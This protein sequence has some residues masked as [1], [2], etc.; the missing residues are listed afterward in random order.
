MAFQIN[1]PR[2]RLLIEVTGA[3]VG[4]V[5]SC[6]QCA[7]SFTVPSPPPRPKVIAHGSPLPTGAPGRPAAAPKRRRKGPEGWVLGLVLFLVFLAFQ[8]Y[9]EFFDRPAKFP[10]LEPPRLFESLQPSNPIETV[11]KADRDAKGKILFSIVADPEAIHQ[12]IRELSALDVTQ[13]PG[14]IRAA[15]TQIV[16]HF[17]AFAAESKALTKQILDGSDPNIGKSVT[18]TIDRRRALLNAALHE[19]NVLAANYG[20]RVAE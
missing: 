1:C 18:A 12:V 14:D 3:D 6:P 7:T 16:G 19:L 15:H 20:V 4:A 17:R 13:C 10:K 5:C 11:V 8:I 2:C 9:V